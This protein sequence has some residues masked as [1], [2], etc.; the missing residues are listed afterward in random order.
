MIVYN[1]NNYKRLKGKAAV[2]EVDED[3]T[4][5]N[6]LVLSHEDNLEDV[7]KSAKSIYQQFNNIVGEIKKSNQNINLGSKSMSVF[8]QT[9][10]KLKNDQQGI[11]RL[12]KTELETLQKQNRQ[13]LSNLDIANQALQ[14]QIDNN[15]LIGDELL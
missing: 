3:K 7:G 14:N 2:E 9:A 4:L 11:T 12:S 1:N 10:E 15:E 13:A 6:D 5:L 8:Q